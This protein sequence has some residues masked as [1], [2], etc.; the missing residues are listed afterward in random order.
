[1]HAHKIQQDAVC[2]LTSALGRIRLTE[3]NVM[4]KK[5]KQTAIKGMNLYIISDNMWPYHCDEN[6]VYK[7]KTV[8]I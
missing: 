3:T 5:Q 1:M 8:P 7:S 4:E 2:D 6:Y